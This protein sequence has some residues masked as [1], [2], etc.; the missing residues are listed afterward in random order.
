L[1]DHSTAGDSAAMR[2]SALAKALRVLGEDPMRIPIR[3]WGRVLVWRLGLRTNVEVAGGLV[4][5]G[6]P[7]IDIRKGSR[8][9]IG[10]R[11][12]LTSRNKGYHLNMHS[13]MK[14]FADR[15]GA[16]ICIG[17]ETRIAGTCIH[18]YESIRIGKR[19]LISANCQ[20]LDGNAHDLSFPDV[21]Q[22]IHSRGSSRPIVIEDDVWIGANSIILAGARIGRGAV[23]GAGSVVSGTVAALTVVRGNPARVVLD[24]NALAA[25]DLPSSDAEEKSAA[26]GPAS[27][28][29]MQ[30]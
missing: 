2:E 10:K 6:R 25:R 8:L 24:Y 18:A 28:A 13:P 7:L 26:E 15:T 9:V 29:S 11:V 21:E 17:D 30:S 1:T 20:I 12:T 3:L 19:C 27:P 23:I 14:I 5:M 16:E 4:L 22:R